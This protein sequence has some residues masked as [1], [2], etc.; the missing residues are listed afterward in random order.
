MTYNRFILWLMTLALLFSLVSCRK[1]QEEP[2]GTLS[3]PP[4]NNEPAL[5]DDEFYGSPD[6]IFKAT[7]DSVKKEYFTNPDGDPAENAHVTLYNL[8][9]LELYKGSFGDEFGYP[10][11]FPLKIYNGEGLAADAEF[12]RFR[13]EVGQEYILGIS[14]LTDSTACYNDQGGYVIEKEEAWTFVMNENGKYENLVEGANHKEWDIPT[15]KEKINYL[16]RPADQPPQVAPLYTVDKIKKDPAITKEQREQFFDFVREWRVD[17]MSDFTL[18]K[19]MPLEQ[20]KYYCAYFVTEEEKTY[21]DMGV[22]YTGAAVERIAERFGTSYGLKAD[23]PVFVKAGSLKDLPFAELI[24]YKE[25]KVNGKTLVTARCINYAIPA[26]YNMDWAHI[27]ETDSYPTHRAMILDGKVEGYESYSVY[28]FSYYT[29]SGKYPAQFVSFT[30]YDAQSIADGSR[31]LPDFIPG[32]DA[33]IATETKVTFSDSPALERIGN[34][35]FYHGID[36]FYPAYIDKK[37]TEFRT[38]MK[39]TPA[40]AY[41]LLDQGKA[42][43]EKKLCEPIDMVVVG[44]IHLDWHSYRYPEYSVT[45]INGPET[46][47]IIGKPNLVPDFLYEKMLLMNASKDSVIVRSINQKITITDDVYYFRIQRFSPT[48]DGKQ[49]DF[50]ELLKNDPQATEKLIKQA[51]RDAKK[52]LCKKNACYD[53]GTVRYDYEKY[54]IFNFH[55]FNS[56]TEDPDDYLEGIVISLAGMSQ[57]LVEDMVFHGVMMI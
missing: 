57:Q 50:K 7:V 31:P 13:L 3:A 44:G 4:V 32:E 6:F 35:V 52:G 25:E 2:A 48:I 47:I 46:F 24:Q 12:E 38:T 28:D 42:D 27:Q 21:V 49:V 23:E 17:A 56:K 8:T 30:C 10:S 53:G 41:K 26:Y 16:Y 19:L 11:P 54:T 51:D 9:I 33:Q 1:P 39:N 45:V 14:Y 37:D 40:F 36:S 34:G 20:F 18:E 22:N 55:A 15:L 5:T 43:A 29:V